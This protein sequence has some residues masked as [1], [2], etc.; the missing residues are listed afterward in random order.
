MQWDTEQ[1]TQQ[2]WSALCIR[3]VYRIKN[4]FDTLL[5]WLGPRYSSVA[6]SMSWINM[7][8]MGLHTMFWVEPALQSECQKRPVL[9]AHDAIP[10]QNAVPSHAKKGSKNWD[11]RWSLNNRCGSQ[12]HCHCFGNMFVRKLRDVGSRPPPCNTICTHLT[13]YKSQLNHLEHPKDAGTCEHAAPFFSAARAGNLCFAEAPEFPGS[14]FPTATIW[15]QCRINQV[16]IKNIWSFMR[17]CFW[18]SFSL[19]DGMESF[20]L[21]MPGAAPEVRIVAS[22]PFWIYGGALPCRASRYSSL[23][24]PISCWCPSLPGRKTKRKNIVWT[25]SKLRN[26]WNCCPSL[27]S[28]HGGLWQ[29]SSH[30]LGHC[31]FAPRH[32]GACVST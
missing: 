10:W 21:R 16:W 4:V 11:K 6:V 13:F 27:R 23:L 30:W 32:Q 26:A 15:K 14:S 31:W 12:L 7:F 29:W 22:S 17:W 19:P 2:R 28:F 25:S 24:K 20:R 1:T 18:K 9:I 8:C 3:K 5:D